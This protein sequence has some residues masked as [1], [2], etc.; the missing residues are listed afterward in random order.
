[1]AVYLL[2]VPNGLD[3]L[4][5]LGGWTNPQSPQRYIQNAIALQAQNHLRTWQNSLYPETDER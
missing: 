1:M 5:Y 2:D 3:Q 4:M